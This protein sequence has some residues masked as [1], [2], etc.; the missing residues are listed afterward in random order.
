MA[1]FKRPVAR[2]PIKKWPPPAR[3]TAEEWDEAEQ[4]LEGLPPGPLAAAGGH[5]VEAQ[6]T[7]LADARLHPAQRQ[8]VA[9]EIGRLQGNR[10]LQRVIVTTGRGDR[11]TLGRGDATRGGREALAAPAG[12]PVV[13]LW[14]DPGALPDWSDAQ[15]R[16]IQ[17]QL[18]RMGFY[19]LR[20]DGIYGPGTQGALVE[21]FGGE[22]WR[23]LEP[24]AI[25]SRL[26]TAEA[27][28]GRRGEHRVRYG[29]MFKDGI[30]DMT[31]GIGF[32]EAG[33]HLNTIN[34]FREVLSARHFTD[35]RSAAERLYREAGRTLGPSAFGVFF[36]RENALTY[37]PPAGSPRPI[38]AV[39]RL[40]QSATGAEGGQA[41]A[42]FREGMV[43][44]DIA[45]YTGHGRYGSGPDFDRNMSYE[46]LDAEGNV[47]Q[48]VEDYDVLERILRGE[49]RRRGRSAWQQ[50]L[51]RERHHRINV[52]GQNA[53]NVVLNPT[54]RHAHEFG[55]RLMY[56]NL[57][58]TGGAGATTAT[59]PGG[60]LAT[61]AGASPERRYRLLVFDGCR[62]RDYVTSIRR[63]PGF[64]ER[65]ADILATRRTVGWGD[66]VGTLAAF[67][68][69]ILEQQSAEQIVRGIDAQQGPER[70]GGRRGGA[71]GGYGLG[72]NPVVR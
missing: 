28:R 51:W 46:L 69:S 67:L 58:R 16:A 33:H 43:Q 37:T 32:D 4:R 65:E 10:H 19:R 68:D 15:L 5:A 1:T 57:R 25:E 6:A 53:G 56:W 71:Y 14:E 39:I 26:S 48:Q 27:P 55:S 40:L 72:E 11:A 8:A 30:L 31:L 35:N 12:S 49:G 24:D 66:E 38:H 41:S 2:E 29:E 20:I 59:G 23:R 36:V 44:S 21:A 42:A 70:R 62:T 3:A 50:F 45:Y 9:G 47:V 60:E 34:R 18:R 61:A 54:N 22:E 52:I 13:Q 17:R 63:T 64:G 7:R